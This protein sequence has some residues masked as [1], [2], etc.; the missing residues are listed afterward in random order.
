[1]PRHI[2]CLT[3]DFDT[4]SGFI[5][6][7]M[8][9]P[10][11]LS[12][13]EFGLVGAQRILGLLKSFG[14]RATWFIPGFTIESHPRACEAVVRDGHEVAHHSW[15]HIPPAQ[16]S[17]RGRGGGYRPRQRGDRPADRPQ[18][19]RLPLAGM[20][21]EREHDRSP[22]G[23]W[24]SLRLEPDG[25]GLLALPRAA[26]RPGRAGQT[27][28]V[29]RGNVADRNAD[30]LV[31]RRLSAFRVRAHRDHGAARIAVG[32]DGD[33]ELARRVPLHAEDGRLGRADLHHASLRDRPR[34]PHAGVRG[35][36]EEPARRRRRV[37]DHGGCR[38]GSAGTDVRR[39]RRRTPRI[40]CCT[41][42]RWPRAAPARRDR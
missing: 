40:R 7:G 37:H 28:W 19:P 26:R 38:E 31:A 10:T 24:I 17:A 14:L 23:A 2:V 22:A 12:R 39:V 33:G 11:P 13:G 32:A 20:G 15:A 21:P 30:Q 25:R 6:R 3:Y 41:A 27:L 18:G 8:T 16:Q 9:T 5:A 35:A 4:Q 36:G 42:A 29:R 34:L 1:M